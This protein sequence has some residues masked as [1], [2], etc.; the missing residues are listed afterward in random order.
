LHV[1]GRFVSLMHTSGLMGGG[2]QKVIFTWTLCL[3]GHVGFLRQRADNQMDDR[4]RPRLKVDSSHPTLGG[5]RE[6]EERIDG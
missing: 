6:K 4:E 3:S 1:C 2:G 5:G